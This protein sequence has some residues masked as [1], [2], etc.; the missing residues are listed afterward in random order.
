MQNGIN[1]KVFYI[2]FLI[3]KFKYLN[4]K[5]AYEFFP[6]L[7]IINEYLRIKIIKIKDFLIQFF[8]ESTANKQQL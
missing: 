5:V 3:N 4:I 8:A 1:E 7:T 6:F 2:K